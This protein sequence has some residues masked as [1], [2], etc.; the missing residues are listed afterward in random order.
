MSTRSA[1]I[2]QTEDGTYAG[3]YCQ[4]D[5]YLEGVG[6]TLLTHYQDANKVKNL[7]DLGFISQLQERVSPM[8]PHSYKCPEEGTT[9]AYHRDRSEALEICT[10]KTAE[11]VAE[12]IGHGGYVYVFRDGKWF[13][14]GSDLKERLEIER[15]TGK[16]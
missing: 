15:R 1:I 2:R 9:V 3:I 11:E 12:Q 6:Y 10:A 7:I 13:V 5:G 4:F 14:N 16:A 8:G